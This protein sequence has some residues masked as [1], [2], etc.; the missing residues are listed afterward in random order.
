ML[1]PC[2]LACF[3]HHYIYSYISVGR[4]TLIFHKKSDVD[5]HEAPRYPKLCVSVQTLNFDLPDLAGL[6]GSY[7]HGKQS[8]IMDVSCNI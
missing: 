5:G 7:N 2:F 6:A 4:H 8:R 1:L 3:L